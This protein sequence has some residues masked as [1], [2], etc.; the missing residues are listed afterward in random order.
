[1]TPTQ[2]DK[3]RELSFSIINYLSASY[4]GKLAG[5]TLLGQLGHASFDEEE[6]SR[7]LNVTE[8]I[9]E[10]FAGLMRGELLFC[11]SWESPETFEAQ[12][13]LGLL[14]KLKPELMDTARRVDDFLNGTGVINSEHAKWLFM[15]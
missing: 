9:S 14:S 4:R 2:A 11:A 10:W 12:D 6:I 13:A 1:M 7:L 3:D 15:P 8:K 5:F